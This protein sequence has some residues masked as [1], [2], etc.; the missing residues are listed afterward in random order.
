LAHEPFNISTADELMSGRGTE[1]KSLIN[2]VL[3][4][5]PKITG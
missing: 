1:I 4:P 2:A 5:A 3:A